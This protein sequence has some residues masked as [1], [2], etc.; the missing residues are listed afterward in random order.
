ML[1]WMGEEM[2]EQRNGSFLERGLVLYFLC[3]WYLA[4]F[5]EQSLH[6]VDALSTW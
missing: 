2:N 3:P 5:L 1:E 4:L 6:P